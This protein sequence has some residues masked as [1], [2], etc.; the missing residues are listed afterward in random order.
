VD[1]NIVEDD[2]VESDHKESADVPAPVEP[3][4][5]AE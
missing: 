5:D 3:A 1:P 4:A 2:T